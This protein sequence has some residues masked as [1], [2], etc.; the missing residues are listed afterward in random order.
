MTSDTSTTGQRQSPFAKPRAR[1]RVCAKRAAQRTSCWHVVLGGPRR[2]AAAAQQSP[3]GRTAAMHRDARLTGVVWRLCAPGSTCMTCI[4]RRCTD[5]VQRPASI[6]F[7]RLVTEWTRRCRV[8]FVVNHTAISHWCGSPRGTLAQPQRGASSHQ[9]APTILAIN[10][11]APPRLHLGRRTSHS[12]APPVGDRRPAAV[13]KKT[14][15]KLCKCALTPMS[16]PPG[17][18]VPA[19]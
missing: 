14:T 6:S 7:R 1:A 3:I 9:A 8:E 4:L 15:S 16:S 19:G 2:P 18:D 13:T 10:T 17:S 11:H 12:R 5:L